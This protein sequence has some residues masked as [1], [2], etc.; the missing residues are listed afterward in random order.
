MD[1]KSFGCSFIYGSELADE[2][3]GVFS[4]LTWPALYAKK[5][6]HN[7]QCYARPGIGNLQIAEQ[8]LKQITTAQLNDVFVIG[9]TWIDRFD[10]CPSNTTDRSRDPWRTIMPV[11]ET[12]LARTYYKEL[13]SEYRD[14]LTT[15]INMKLVIDSLREKNIRF[16]MTYMDDLTFDRRWNTSSAAVMLQG[17]AQPHMTQFNGMSFLS[18]S[19]ANGFAESVKWH[20]LEDAHAAAA[21]YLI[22]QGLL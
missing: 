5:L 21:Q 6:G 18:W 14:K 3:P 10:Y 17:L 9:W 13:H 8:V 7:Y 1:I 16:I 2:A 4:H 20:P 19:R 11:D 15:L 22:D 12:A